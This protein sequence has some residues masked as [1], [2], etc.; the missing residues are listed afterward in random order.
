MPAAEACP[1]VHAAFYL[2]YGTPAIDGKWLHWDHRTMPHWTA[3]MNERFP[4]GVAHTPP[5]HAHSPYY[6]ARGLYSSSDNAT[7]LAQMR[8]LA[9]AGVDPSAGSWPQTVPSLL[10]KGARRGRPSAPSAQVFLPSRHSPPCQV[11]ALR[12][13]LRHAE[14]VGPGN[15]ATHPATPQPAALPRHRHTATP[16]PA[17][18]YTAA[19][20][21]LLTR[22]ASMPG[23]AGSS[24]DR[25][26][27]P[28]CV[29][30]PSRT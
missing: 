12:R 14:L 9:E 19:L 30:G 1:F 17:W 27:Q 4:P 10:A 25:A 16:R 20:P 28:G 2:W 13:R 6:P 11:A 22:R 21:S 5:D 18:R 29:H 7:L 23:S 3:K 8:E 26:R 24:A 15:A